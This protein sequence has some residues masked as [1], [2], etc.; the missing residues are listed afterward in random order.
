[1]T[2]LVWRQH[3]KQLYFALAALAVLGASFI[4]T[5]RPMHDRFERAGLPD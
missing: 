2:W 5:G 3:R 4:G 1:M